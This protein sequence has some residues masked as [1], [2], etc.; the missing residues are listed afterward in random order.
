VVGGGAPVDTDGVEDPG[1]VD[2]VAVPDI[3]P[4][5]PGGD[6]VVGPEDVGEPGADGTSEVVELGPREPAAAL[7]AFARAGVVEHPVP[8]TKVMATART[9]T[10]TFAGWCRATSASPRR[11]QS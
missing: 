3:D 11:H 6:V 2:P 9:T 4:L 5:V 8:A 7:L 10:A 1:P